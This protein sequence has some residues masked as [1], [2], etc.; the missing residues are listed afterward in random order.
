MNIRKIERNPDVN[1]MYFG[2]LNI[3]DV[4][5]W[6]AKGSPAI[7]CSEDSFLRIWDEEI[8]LEDSGAY[9]SGQLVVLCDTDIRWWIK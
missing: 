9:L 1:I 8:T 4:F 6:G 7:K 2:D 3:G 5:T